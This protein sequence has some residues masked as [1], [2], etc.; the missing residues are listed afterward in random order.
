[1]SLSGMSAETYELT[2]TNGKWRRVEKNLGELSRVISETGANT[3]VE[4]YFHIYKHNLHEIDA[5]KGMCDE[6]GFRFHPALGI[7]LQPL[8]LKEI[9]SGIKP[10]SAK[11]ADDRLLRSVESLL[12]E[13]REQASQP[14]ILTRVA[15]VI[16]WDSSVLACCS[17]TGEPLFKSYLDVSLDEIIN[18]RTYSAT[19]GTCQSNALHR[20][21]NQA[22]YAPLIEEVLS[23]SGS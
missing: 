4:L 22:S 9:T 17:F 12:S 2:H 8:V 5:A 10:K 16:N 20:W 3:I 23:M 7:I 21:N 19:C 6:Y 11:I 1:V 13:C 18:H 15:P 14:C